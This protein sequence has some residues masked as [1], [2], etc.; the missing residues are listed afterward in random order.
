LAET[1]LLARWCPACRRREP[2]LRL[3]R[4]TW[5]GWPRY[6]RPTGWREGARAS[7]GTCEALSTVAGSAFGPTH[8]SEEAPVMGVER[9]GRT[10]L[11]KFVRATRGFWEGSGGRTEVEGEA[12]QYLEAARVGGIPECQSQQR[13]TGSGWVLDRGL[14]GRSEEQPLSDL[15]QDVLGELLPAS[16]GGGGD[17]ES[18]RGS[19]NSRRAHRRR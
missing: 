3:S 19:E 5:E 8:S 12:V 9:R 18:A 13:G 1:R 4:G 16:G 6:C 17:T 11:V 2:G 10:I 7:G 15:E 14:R